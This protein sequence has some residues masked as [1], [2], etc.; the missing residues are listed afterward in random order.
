[1]FDGEDVVQEALAKAA[2]ALPAASRIENMERWLFTIAH[3]TALDN[4]RRRKRQGEVPLADEAGDDSVPDAGTESWVA[5]NASLATMMQLPV[6]QRSVVVLADVLEYSAEETAQILDSTVPAVKAA[7][8]RG[9]ARLKSL[10]QASEP[11]H[12]SLSAEELSRL[13]AY[14]DSFNARDFDTLRN[15]LAE[16]V[17]LDLVNRLRLSGRKD[18]AV[19]F[20]RYDEKNDWKIS[21]GLAEDRLALSVSDPQYASDTPIYVVLLDWLDGKI[22]NIRDFRWA[23]YVTDGMVFKRL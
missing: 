14:A 1:V 10:S 15:L 17:K 8:H 23:T 12:I 22:R 20:G 11:E 5:A 7:L 18:V 9:R 21:V 2:E 4:L 3:N 13:R 16:D 6:I 19:Y